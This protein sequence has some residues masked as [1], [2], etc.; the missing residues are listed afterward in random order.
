M[1]G[2]CQ[3]RSGRTRRNTAGSSVR[4]G[5]EARFG[6]CVSDRC[7]SEAS[8]ASHR[9]KASRAAV[10]ASNSSVSV[11]KS[12]RLRSS[13]SRR[14]CVSGTQP[15]RLLRVELRRLL[16]TVTFVN[17]SPV[18]EWMLLLARHQPGGWEPVTSG[19]SGAFV[20][21]GADGSRFAKCVPAGKQDLLVQNGIGSIGSAPVASQGPGCSTGS[22]PL[23]AGV[24]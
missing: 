13:A 4:E 19:D 2:Q 5:R 7:E 24:W 18:R 3:R 1:P 8:P 17:G 14:S 6:V 20:F 21:R 22:L 10:T 16:A 11:C 23:V 12:R 9:W 15:P